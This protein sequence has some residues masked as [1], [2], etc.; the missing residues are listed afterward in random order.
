MKQTPE[1]ER[2]DR[3]RHLQLAAEQRSEHGVADSQRH[4][5]DRYK[6]IYTV[7]QQDDSE[8][9][10]DFAAHMERLVQDHAEDASVES[11][12]LGGIGATMLLVMLLAARLIAGFWP[13]FSEPFTHLPWH[14]ILGTGASLAAAWCLDRLLGALRWSVPGH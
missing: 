2:L 5:I 8:P 10:G 7:L 4:D 13:E 11:W 6:F 3:E 14:I 12:I 1:S 9:P